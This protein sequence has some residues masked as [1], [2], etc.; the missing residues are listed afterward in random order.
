MVGNF[1]YVLYVAAFVHVLY[2][3]YYLVFEILSGITLDLQ[4]R[5]AAHQLGNFC[6]PS[7]KLSL[8]RSTPHHFVSYTSV[9]VWSL[10]LDSLYTFFKHETHTSPFSNNSFSCL[11][12]REETLDAEAEVFTGDLNTQQIIINNCER[13]YLLYMLMCMEEQKIYLLLCFRLAAWIT[14]PDVIMNLLT[15]QIVP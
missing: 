6:P 15:C 5:S 2:A 7:T 3:K 10:K 11:D 9:K 12:Q 4:N 8:H 1:Q 13:L 14:V